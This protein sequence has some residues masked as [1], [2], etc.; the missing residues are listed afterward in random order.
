[1]M[2]LYKSNSFQLLLL[3]AINLCLFSKGDQRAASTHTN[4]RN[5]G[6]CKIEHLQNQNPLFVGNDYEVLEILHHDPKAFTYVQ[7]NK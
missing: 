5:D 6:H 3:T 1:M 7:N 4:D 2:K